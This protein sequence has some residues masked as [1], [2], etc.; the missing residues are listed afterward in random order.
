MQ[1]DIADRPFLFF[2]L[3]SQS[4]SAAADLEDT[5]NLLT[6]L[7]SMASLFSL[8]ELSS[9]ASKA[10]LQLHRP[11]YIARWCTLNVLNG[12]W[13][14][15]YGTLIWNTLTNTNRSSAVNICLANVLIDRKDLRIGDIH[16]F[17]ALLKQI[18]IY[19]NAFL[20]RIHK[21]GWAA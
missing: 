7:C 17:I 9:A 6:G 8:P 16:H 12:F 2:L 3:H 13:D 11:E 1:L 20:A 18:L 10:L 5:R 4:K 21:V 15:R 14:I 19:R